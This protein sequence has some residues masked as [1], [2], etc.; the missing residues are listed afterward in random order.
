MQ[1]DVLELPLV[2][3]NRAFFAHEG[4]F[5]WVSEGPKRLI[6]AVERDK[7]VLTPWDITRSFFSAL[8]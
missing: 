7:G 4:F 3:V 8:C 6:D 1:I 2:I 5:A